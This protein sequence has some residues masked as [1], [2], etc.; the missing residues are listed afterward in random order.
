MDGYIRV[1][2]GI[3][4]EKGEGYIELRRGRMGLRREERERREERDVK[5]ER[6]ERNLRRNK[7]GSW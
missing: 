1:R 2:G 7:G 6:E 3:K 4:S 5:V